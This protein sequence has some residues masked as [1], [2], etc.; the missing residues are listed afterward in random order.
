LLHEQLAWYQESVEG[1]FATIRV[2]GRPSLRTR[3]PGAVINGIDTFRYG[4]HA[5]CMRDDL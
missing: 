2:S 3:V 4:H 1:H 5:T